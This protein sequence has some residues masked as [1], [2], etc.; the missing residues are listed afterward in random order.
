MRRGTWVRLHGHVLHHGVCISVCFDLL[1]F[2]KHSFLH[3]NNVNGPWLRPR[4]P[5]EH[6]DVGLELFKGVGMLA[7]RDLASRWRHEW[8]NVVGVLLDLCG[9]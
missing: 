9:G 2:L 3:R 1:S 8:G 4:D 5:L 6:L 7:P